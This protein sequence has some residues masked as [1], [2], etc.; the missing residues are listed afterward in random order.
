ML[1]HGR[2]RIESLV[3][4]YGASGMPI[5]DM[6]EALCSDVLVLSST[7]VVDGRYLHRPQESVQVEWALMRTAGTRVRL[8]SFKFERR[9]APPLVP[10]TDFDA[11]VVD[12]DVPEP[13]AE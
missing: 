10:L 9:A 12:S 7:T 3:E 5:R 13:L 11:V 8:N 6:A 2:V 4:Q 1:A